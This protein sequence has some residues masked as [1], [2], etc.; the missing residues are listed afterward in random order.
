MNGSVRDCLNAQSAKRDGL[1]CAVKLVV[2]APRHKLPQGQPVI[3][4]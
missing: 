1:L 4:K 2:R 3:T